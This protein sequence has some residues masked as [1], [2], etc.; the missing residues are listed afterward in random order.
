MQFRGSAFACVRK[1]FRLEGA[2]GQYVKP[3]SGR[4][5]LLTVNMRRHSPDIDDV[6]IGKWAPTDVGAD[7]ITRSSEGLVAWSS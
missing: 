3:V 1:L 2:G 4:I 6:R 7:L 5:P